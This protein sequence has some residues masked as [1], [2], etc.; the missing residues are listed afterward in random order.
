MDR[1]N[2]LT[3]EKILVHSVIYVMSVC[4]WCFNIMILLYY[5]ISIIYDTCCMFS[6]LDFSPV[7]VNTYQG[8]PP[9]TFHSSLRKDVD[10]ACTADWEWWEYSVWCNGKYVGLV[11]YSCVTYSWSFGPFE[12]VRIYWW[13]LLLYSFC[14]HSNS[15]RLGLMSLKACN[16]ILAVWIHTY[17]VHI[18]CSFSY[19]IIIIF[20]H[21]SLAHQWI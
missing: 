17:I 11:S 15:S 9:D 6:D 3:L 21:C 18:V 7:F 12:N 16:I 1:K 10:D 5:S 20:V 19:T 2:Q 14:S 8:T 13:P 4:N